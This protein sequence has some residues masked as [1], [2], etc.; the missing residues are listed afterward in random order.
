MKREGTSKTYGQ[1]ILSK[2]SVIRD[3]AEV[4]PVKV[5]TLNSPEDS[6]LF[7]SQEI[8]TQAIVAAANTKESS[9][10]VVPPPIQPSRKLTNT[11]DAS[12]VFP[13]PI[14]SKTISVL[15]GI[16]LP[17]NEVLKTLTE[18]Q[19]IDLFISLHSKQSNSIE[20]NTL[21]VPQH[22]I[23]FIYQHWKGNES[24]IVTQEDPELDP[25]LVSRLKDVPRYVEI[26]WDIVEV[27]EQITENVVPRDRETENLKQKIFRAPRGVEKQSNRYMKN[28]SL[29]KEDSHKGK[30]VD[31][32]EPELGMKSVA[33]KNEFVN[34]V[35]TTIDTKKRS[36][37]FE[38][39][40][41]SSK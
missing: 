19:K 30:I 22:S 23:K 5:T 13:T 2:N 37:P 20:F 18:A 1:F 41:L 31:I 33:N 36:D 27:E 14:S 6:P 26:S 12:L 21:K 24:N 16:T 38:F 25:L 34:T 9:A 3:S 17:K 7:L 11:S 35:K 32:H 8:K 4:T 39:L 10:I 28:L 40:G 29:I 15:N